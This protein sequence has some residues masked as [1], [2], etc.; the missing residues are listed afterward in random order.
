MAGCDESHPAFRFLVRIWRVPQCRLAEHHTPLILGL[1]NHCFVDVATVAKLAGHS[2]PRTTLRYDR[3]KMETRRQ[4][5]Q[6]LH[7]PYKRRR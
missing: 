6:T 1:E 4:A 5:I 3:R 2:E 7:V